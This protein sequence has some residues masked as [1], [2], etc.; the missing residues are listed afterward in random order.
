MPKPNQAPW[1]RGLRIVVGASLLILGF[2][3]G[4]EGLPGAALRIFGWLP[5]L[6]G[7]LGWDPVY[8]FFGWRTHPKAPR[9]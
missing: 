2:F 8:A 6:T 1:D 3:G 5:L 9:E 7:L 4:V